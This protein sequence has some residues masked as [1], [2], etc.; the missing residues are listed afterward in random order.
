MINKNTI[1]ILF[2]IIFIFIIYNVNNDTEKKTSN[3]DIII[4]EKL[5]VKKYAQLVENNKIINFNPER[6]LIS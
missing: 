6:I 4:L 3:P 2:I 5:P 1:I